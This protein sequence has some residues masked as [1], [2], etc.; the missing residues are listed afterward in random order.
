MARRESPFRPVD[1]LGLVDASARYSD[2]RC[3]DAGRGMNIPAALLGL[4]GKLIASCQ[5]PAGD[6]FFDSA[7]MARFA[8]AA[9][10]GG[11]ADKSPYSGHR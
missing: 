10:A 4:K 9:I 3:L 8:Q 6:A 5:A 2:L 11:A 1:E 7:S